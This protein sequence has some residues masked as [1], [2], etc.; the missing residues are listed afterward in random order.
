[1]GGRALNRH[2]TF[3]PTQLGRT[4]LARRQPPSPAVTVC[5][6]GSEEVRGTVHLGHLHVTVSSLPAVRAGC[7]GRRR[8]RSQDVG[9]ARRYGPLS[10]RASV[11]TFPSFSLSL[12]CDAGLPHGSVTEEANDLRK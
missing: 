4:A 6:G 11:V 8:A 3:V 7:G 10:R 5:S 12:S 1:M 2:V 9:S